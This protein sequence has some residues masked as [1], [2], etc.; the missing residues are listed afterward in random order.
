MIESLSDEWSDSSPGGA[1]CNYDI[2]VIK[3]L[4][5][6]ENDEQSKMAW[7]KSLPM[8]VNVTFVTCFVLPIFVF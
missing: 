1:L 6:V 2:N 5:S 7:C 8:Y 3:L 4:W